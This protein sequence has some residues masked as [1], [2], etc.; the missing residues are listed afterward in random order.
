MVSKMKPMCTPTAPWPPAARGTSR[1]R[2]PPAPAGLLPPR[3]S[4]FFVSA[5]GGVVFPL[6]E[7]WEAE[8][9]KNLSL[10]IRDRPVSFSRPSSTSRSKVES[11]G[12]EK[13]ERPSTKLSSRRKRQRGPGPRPHCGGSG[14][15]GARESFFFNA[16]EECGHP[17]TVSIEGRGPYSHRV[18]LI[19]VGHASSLCGFVAAKYCSAWWLHEPSDG[20][21]WRVN[22]CS[23]L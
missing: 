7:W 9:A 20:L 16:D 23:T 22:F 13:V 11:A 6:R 3:A 10:A 2:A 14:A 4:S 17:S 8:M 5:P 21:A 18:N 19:R 15:D 1:G 12:G